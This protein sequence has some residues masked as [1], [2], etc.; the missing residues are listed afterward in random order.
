[1]YCQPPI[2]FADS[3][4]GVLSFSSCMSDMRTVFSKCSSFE[5]S[6]YVMYFSLLWFFPAILKVAA[7]HSTTG[8]SIVTVRPAAQGGKSP[9]TLTSLPAGVR[10]VVPAQSTQGT[11]CRLKFQ[12]MSICMCMRVTMLI[13]MENNL[14]SKFLKH[15]YT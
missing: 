3:V 15:S 9:V 2:R 14:M 6:V 7:P 4:I 8:T 12:F 10:M 1:M 5:M 11:V 13:Q